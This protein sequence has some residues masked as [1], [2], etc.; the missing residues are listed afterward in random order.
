MQ[1]KIKILNRQTL[2]AVDEDSPLQIQEVSGNIVDIIN[3]KVYQGKL[4]IS[5]G[6]IEDIIK[7]D[8]N[9]NLFIIPP[10]VDSHVHIESSMLAP[11]AY[12][13]IALIQG[14][15]A[16]VSDPHEIANVM[17]IEGIRFMIYEGANLPFRFYFGAPS[18]VPAT[19]METSGAAITAQDIE[20]LFK[21]EK[22]H[23]LSE[24]MNFPG[25][26]N[27]N[28][29]VMQKIAVAKSYGRKI[30]GHAPGLR[31]RDLDLYL[32]A[33]IS[34]DHETITYDEGREKLQKGM[35]LLIR[36]GSAAKNLDELAPLIN[37]FPDSCMF[38][39]DDMHPDDIQKGYINKTIKRLLHKGYDIFKLLCCAC[40]NPAVHYSIDM[41]FIQ[42]ND[43][44]DFLLVDNLE[45]FNVLCTVIAGEAVSINSKCLL[46]LSDVQH[47]NNFCAS[48]K[49]PEDFRVEAQGGIIKVI[50]AID[51]QI[52]TGKLLAKQKVVAGMTVSDT[53]RDI[54][55]ISVISRYE[56]K[57]PVMG[58][59]KNFG[60]K[61][62]AIASSVSHDSHNII[63]VGVTDEDI[64]SAVNSVI[65][66]KGG[67]ALSLDGVTNTLPLPV[68]GLMSD[69][70]VSY[71]A[72][73]Y[74]GLDE[75]AK[76]LGS[77]LSAPFMT[78]SFMGLTVI[79]ELKISDRGLFDF[80]A[81]DY[82]SLFESN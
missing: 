26:I 28:P 77:R 43:R 34:T 78:L 13:H 11:K 55:K 52:Y 75:M 81:F 17:G 66:H 68:A 69:K 25:V 6:I 31:G 23:Y 60:L 61:K 32:E 58:F 18:C 41:G 36:E 72:H 37:E 70:D 64:A 19:P 39:S 16:C 56:D 4:M 3:K 20:F 74:K 21:E 29:D 22:L 24:M 10:L 2:K 76:N 50:E 1:K 71:V 63:A 38:C 59:V 62:G 79:P 45:D 40:L 5:N 12:A 73:K 67:L 14:V 33:G 54:L 80:N 65:K 82:V 8:T 49:K 47:I 7:T 48:E 30:D 53:E 46:P 51:G 35:K 57:P 42:R 44:A 27:R 9:S 15:A